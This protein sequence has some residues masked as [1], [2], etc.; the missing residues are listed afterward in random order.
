MKRTT[1]F[2]TLLTMLAATTALAAD[3]PTRFWNLTAETITEFRLAPA[4]TSK[5]GINQCDNDT[6]GSVDTDEMLDIVGVRPGLYD[7]KFKDHSGRTCT[8]KGL[9]IKL[10]EVFS[11][12]EK[13]LNDCTK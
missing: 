6:D 13:Q 1:V 3:K 2:A 5:W 8:V 12:E 7:A 10:H 4:G 11:I 9:R